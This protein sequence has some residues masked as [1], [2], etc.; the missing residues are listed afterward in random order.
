MA[1]PACHDIWVF[2]EVLPVE[3]VNFANT[4]G[5]T[6]FSTSAVT[7]WVDGST[8]FLGGSPTSHFATSVWGRFLRKTAQRVVKLSRVLKKRFALRSR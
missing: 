5:T 4:R 6:R 7:Q 3:I 8:H 1:R 2:S